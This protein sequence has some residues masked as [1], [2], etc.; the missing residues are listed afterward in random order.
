MAHHP[1]ASDQ[2]G[3][4]I[5]YR[6]GLPRDDLRYLSTSRVSMDKQG[7]VVFVAGVHGVGKSHFRD[8]FS[9]LLDAECASASDLIGK[10]RRLAGDKSVQDVGSNQEALI[11]EI[12]LLRSCNEWIVLDGHFCVVKVGGEIEEVSVD[13]FREIGLASIVLLVDDVSQ[14]R[15]RLVSR[16]G[17]SPF[18]L[19][20]LQR[21]Q[22]K[23]IACAI[24]TSH[25]LSCPLVRIEWKRDWPEASLRS[26]IR[27]CRL[28]P[29]REST[30]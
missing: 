6:A 24:S 27:E 21:L 14:I 7:K 18:D 17:G 22:E 11:Q 26:I 30:S 28:S 3:K 4:V 12:T 13:V 1:V 5:D 19:E 16:D 20:F 25:E 2:R 15:S 29:T 23:E 10:H 8:E 9:S